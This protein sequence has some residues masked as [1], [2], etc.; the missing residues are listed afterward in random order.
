MV[1]EPSQQNL[2]WGQAQ[3]L[4]KC[5]VVLQQPVQ[6][7]VQLDIDLAEQTSPDDLPDQ[8]QNQVL[9]HLDDITTANVDDGTPNA[10][11]RLDNNVVVLGEVEIVQLLDL[12]ARLV[13]DTLV[14]CVGHAVV[15]ELGQHETVLALVEH[16]EGIGGEGQA[17][18]DVRI[19]SEHS[20]DVAGELGALIFVDGVGDV[21]GGAL[22]LDP[23][24]TCAADAGL[25]GVLGGGGAG[26]SAGD[27]A[28]AGWPRVHALLC[29]R[30]LAQLGDEIHIVV[31]LDSPRAVELNLLQGLAHD[32]VRLVLGLLGGLDDGGL[33]EVALVVDVELA[34]GVLQAKDLALL[35]LG[36]LPA[37]NGCQSLQKPEAGGSAWEAEAEAH[38]W[39]L[40]MFMAG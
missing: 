6:F 18:A 29:G 2:L 32:I 27:S 10:L 25:G 17:V 39:S 21:G 36:V 19:A 14:D 28:W 34:E 8:T 24:T 11:G 15:D 4:L 38:L 37:R 30:G 5:L 7:G 12:L 3:E 22:D 16:L 33:V 20:I 1:V 35:E 23:A 9:T 13:Q 31:Q 40:M 26:G